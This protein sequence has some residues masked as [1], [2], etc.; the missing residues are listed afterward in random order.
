MPV[1]AWTALLVAA[2]LSIGVGYFAWTISAKKAA[3]ATSVLES[4]EESV[5]QAALIKLHALVRD[6]RDER[7]RLESIARTDINTVLDTIET[8]GRDTNTKI[9]IGQA[10]SGAAPT[11]EAPLQATTFT[12]SANGSFAKLS[13]VVALLEVLPIP[14]LIEEMQLERI[15]SADPK[16][17][18]WRL[19]MRIRI[20]TT[21]ELSV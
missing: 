1:L 6:T 15:E 16:A 7:A 14:S 11:L 13:Q 18:P 5:K 9:E 19:V 3:R 2:V 10:A 21:T 4:A 17:P 12:I 20:F 8:V